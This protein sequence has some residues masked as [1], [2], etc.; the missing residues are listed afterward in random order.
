MHSL[1]LID[2][3]F[4]SLKDI[5]NDI[6]GF[7]VRIIS[8]TSTKKGIEY[9]KSAPPN[10]LVITIGMKEKDMLECLVLFKRE[11]ITKSIPVLALL[12]DQDQHFVDLLT[13]LGVSDSIPK[14]WKKTV[15]L[16]K[17]QDLLKASESIQENILKETIN[18]I[19]IAENNEEKV[20][21]VFRSGL[22][23][24]VVPEIRSVLT[25]EF[26][27]S[28]ITKQICIDIRIL[29]EMTSEELVI[30]EKIVKLFGSKK[31]SLVAGSHLGSIMAN[32]ELED[33]AYLFLSMEDF[34]L[35]LSNP[36]ALD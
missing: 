31:I 29:P 18:H 8:T 30:L 36:A 9:S 23:L 35:F 17:I 22:K 16:K 21:I 2:N 11:P 12:K 32:T 3:D 27:K 19:G 26:I 34:E 5:E 6:T 33:N 24:F 7:R 28:I 15:L 25:H 20:V 14:P 4:Y 1:I 13:K 10:L